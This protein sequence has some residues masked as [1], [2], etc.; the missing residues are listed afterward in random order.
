MKRFIVW[1]S[2]VCLMIGCLGVPVGAEETV[3]T[4]IDFSNA[5]A[6][7]EE[8][9]SVSGYGD[10]DS[11][12][13]AGTTGGRLFASVSGT[14]LRKLE[15]SKGEYGAEGMQP[16]MTGGTKN[17]WGNGAYIEVRLSTKGYEQITF[18]ADLGA[19]NKGPRDYKLQYSTDGVTFQNVTGATFTVS[20]NK[21]MYTAFDGVALPKEAADRDSLSIR[22]AVASNML[23]NGTAG[24]IGSTGGETAINHVIVKG[25]RQATTAA[26]TKATTAAKDTTPSTG[27]AT[28]ASSQKEPSAQAAQTT[29]T[30]AVQNAA[31]VAA[32]TT[33]S[34]AAAPVTPSA[35]TADVSAATVALGWLTL[36]A[37]GVVWGLSRW[38]R[39]A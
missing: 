25:V 31:G 22:V 17:P 24:L 35:N 13:A 2:I 39:T 30:T 34:H 21:T 5:S 33:A 26:T 9:L 23:V 36:A 28:T 7:A 4:A 19:T 18:S 8:N 6:V 15:W 11:G 38:K 12:Y 16:V 29:S 14:D 27:A 32:V 20:V 37:I 10:K 3:I 1:L